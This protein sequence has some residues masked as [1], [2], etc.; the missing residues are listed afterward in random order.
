MRYGMLIDL[1]RCVGCGACAMAC[2]QEHGTAANVHYCRIVHGETGVYPDSKIVSIPYA[3]MQC[4]NAPCAAA[5]STGATYRDV[6][7][8]IVRVDYETCDGCGACA[9]ECPYDVREFN[10]LEGDASGQYWG[11]DAQATPFEATKAADRVPGAVQKCQFCHERL[12][13]GKLPACVETCIVSARIFGDLDD[14]DGELAQAIAQRG[15]QQA[16]PDEKTGPSVYYVGD[17]SLL[18]A[19]AL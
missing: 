7:T 14:E 1:D 6:D 9:A 5:C 10:P 8:G 4:M 18:D 16:Y 13:E 19:P 11:A 3:C 17:L 15:A 12:E 2:K